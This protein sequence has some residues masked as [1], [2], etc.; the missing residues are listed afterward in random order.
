MTI[1]APVT[2]VSAFGRGMWLAESLIQQQIPV[3]WVDLTHKLGR[4]ELADSEGPFPLFESNTLTEE[5]KKSWQKGAKLDSVQIGSESDLGLIFLTRQG[6]LELK[7]AFVSKRVEHLNL[8]SDNLDYLN[9]ETSSQQRSKYKAGLGKMILAE[10]WLAQWAHRFVSLQDIP[11]AQSLREGKPL[12]LSRRICL[13]KAKPVKERLSMLQGESLFSL[14]S[15]VELEDIAFKDRKTPSGVLVR[16]ET[17]E[18]VLCSN[19]VWA[20]GSAETKFI[21]DHL[22]ERVFKSESKEFHKVWMRWQVQIDAIDL[23]SYFVIL[24][25]PDLPWE[26][27]NFLIFSKDL[28]QGNL[29]SCWMLLPAAQRFNRGYLEQESSDL[30]QFLSARFRSAKVEVKRQPLESSA[31]TREMGAALFGLYREGDYQRSV[32]PKWSHFYQLASESQVQQGPNGNLE[33]ELEIFNGIS[34]WW[35]KELEVIAKREARKKNRD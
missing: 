14:W 8:S 9:D 22:S 11:P 20:L 5:Q 23:P 6:P 16:K 12:P 25:D 21:S 24:D 3:V 10:S 18:V 17:S 32:S 27:Q 34:Q 13:R 35:K 15:D 19:L 30:L 33:K 7:G 28:N 1:P 31:T 29:F 4:L 2:I 26:H